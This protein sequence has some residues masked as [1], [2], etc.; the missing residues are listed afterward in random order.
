MTA[1][2]AQ[3]ER[4]RASSL[5]GILRSALLPLAAL[6]WCSCA[7]RVRVE[8]NVADAVVRVDGETIGRIQ[9]GAS[10]VERRGPR[11]TYDVE[12]S[13][14]GY[15]AERRLLRPTEAEPVSGALSLLAVSAGGVTA[16]CVSPTAA[17][18]SETADDGVAWLGVG[19]LASCAACTGGLVLWG[20]IERLP[21]VVWI[22]LE[23]EGP[24]TNEEGL[25][26]PPVDVDEVVDAVRDGASFGASDSARVSK[27][28]AM[29]H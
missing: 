14:P 5:R 17:L 20:G 12:V 29:A 26:P 3:R 27:P 2:Y 6:S 8:S 15:R 7:H 4:R 18:L 19:A 10:F 16:C 23:P 21:D 1:A 24:G 25:P 13:A 28:R 22:E 11:A 9:D